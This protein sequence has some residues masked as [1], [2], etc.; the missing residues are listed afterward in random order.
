[1]Q[2]VH[3]NFLKEK[4]RQSLPPTS[5]MHPLVFAAPPPPVQPSIGSNT[6]SNANS[7][8]QQDQSMSLQSS[9]SMHPFARSV[10]GSSTN[11]NTNAMEHPDLTLS[12]QSS[13]NMHPS[14][15]AIVGSDLYSSTN[16]VQERAVGSNHTDFQANSTRASPQLTEAVGAEPKHPNLGAAAQ[17]LVG[18]PRLFYTIVHALQA[19]SRLYRFERREIRKHP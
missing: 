10:V 12:L 13:K 16:A 2:I 4:Q 14:A 1:M 11:S 7:L 17:K 19:I 3:G 15:H 5:T 6:H 9:K 18:N 8:Q